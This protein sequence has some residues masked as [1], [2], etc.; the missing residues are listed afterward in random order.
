MEVS[1]VS[2]GGVDS[3]VFVDEGWSGLVDAVVVMVDSGSALGRLIALL[4]IVLLEPEVAL[5]L[6]R[7][8]GGRVA[9]ASLVSSISTILGSELGVAA[10]RSA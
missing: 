6:L 4:G 1:G 5:L 10:C 8:A 7:W 2:V 3:W 9:S